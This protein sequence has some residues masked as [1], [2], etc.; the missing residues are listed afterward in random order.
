MEWNAEQL[1]KLIEQHGAA[2]AYYARQI[3]PSWAG[4]MCDDLLQEALILLLRKKPP[5]DEPVAWLYGTIRRLALFRLRTEGRRVRHE[6]NAAQARETELPPWH[7]DD[8]AERDQI[9]L[10]MKKLVGLDSV[11]QEVVVMHVWGKLTFKEIGPIVGFSSSKT[12][13]EYQRAL[14][15]L[16]E[17]MNY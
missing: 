6:T 7:V 4:S 12:H 10:M 8:L 15:L 13:R 9:E 2:L 3:G 14:R 16:Q 1:K 17:T 11:L 5:P